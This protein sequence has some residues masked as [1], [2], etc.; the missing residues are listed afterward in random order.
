[1]TYKG[2]EF[3]LSDAAFSFLELEF[4]M[5]EAELHFSWYFLPYEKSK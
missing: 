3:W 4:H 2:L 5:L 1:M